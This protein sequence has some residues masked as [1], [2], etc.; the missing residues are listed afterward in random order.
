MKLKTWADL[1]CVI[2]GDQ[3]SVAVEVVEQCPPNSSVMR[4]EDEGARALYFPKPNPDP[5]RVSNLTAHKEGRYEIGGAGFGMPIL[6]LTKGPA[7]VES[8]LVNFWLKSNPHEESSGLCVVEHGTTGIVDYTNS[9]DMK[10]AIRKLDDSEFRNAF[11]RAYIRVKGYDS[12]RS[13]SRSHSRSRS[14]S[15]SR[16]PGRSY[17]RSRSRSMSPKAK[18]SRRSLSRSVSSRSRSGSK[19]RSLSRS[20]SRS[21]SPLPSVRSDRS[22][23]VDSR[24]R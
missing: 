17:S 12:R 15:R 3:P 23:S 21:R 6:G 18:Y 11:S 14:Y 8:G 4:L 22:Q 1:T 7:M 9:D 10:Y 13:L 24:G 5:P 2:K 20:R 19:P 16:S